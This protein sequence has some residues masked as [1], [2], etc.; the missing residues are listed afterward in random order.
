M[1]ASREVAAAMREAADLGSTKFPSFSHVSPSHFSLLGAL[2]KAGQ[3]K[4]TEEEWLSI[5]EF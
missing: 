1:A 2:K 4:K 5:L 3:K